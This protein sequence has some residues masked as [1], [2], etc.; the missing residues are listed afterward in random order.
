MS[1]F[2]NIFSFTALILFVAFFI[3]CKNNR[4][5]A[6]SSNDKPVLLED[7]RFQIDVYNIGEKERW[8]LINP[9]D[10]GW[11]KVKIPSA[12]NTY[13]ESLWGYEGV[14]WYASI[15]PYSNSLKSKILHL[16]FNRVNYD[17]QVWLNGKF[18]G[19]NRG[20]FLPFEFDISGLLNKKRDNWLV[21]RVDN[22]PR[23]NWLP[24]SKQ[25][26][27]VQY[28]GILQPVELIALDSVFIAD[29]HIQTKVLDKQA[30]ILFGLKI[31]NR[32]HKNR[33]IHIIV[34]IS[35]KST[36]VSQ[37]IGL[38]CQSNEITRKTIKM[39]VDN[40]RLWSPESPNLYDL[41]VVLK[42]GNK[43]CDVKKYRFGVRSIETEGRNIL[44]NGKPLKIK[45]FNRYDIFARMGHVNNREVIKKD[46]LKIKKS[47]ANVIRVHYPQ[48]PSTLD[49]LDEI[50]L[51]LIEELP[52]NWWGQNWWTDEK[53][54]Q[55]TTILPQARMM[56][57]KM[58]NRDKNHPSVFAWSLANECKT[59][60]KTGT[61]VVQELIKEAHSLDSSRL[62]TFSVN[63]D[64]NAHPAYAMADFV[65]CNVYFGNDEAYHEAMLDSLVRQPAEM[66]IKRQCSVYPHKPMIVSEFGAAGIYGLSGNVSFSED[67]QAEYIEKIWKAIVNVPQCSGGILWCWA[68]YYHRKY[69]TQSYSPFG[70]YGVLNV[71][72]KEKKSFKKIKQFF[73]TY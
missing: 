12:W 14:A 71:E 19:E 11:K 8:Y 42:N 72:R 34:T 66:F 68:D 37:I 9:Y 35:D 10:N 18:I 53:V 41:K 58:V 33:D 13:D 15:I 6:H 44:L 67:W 22:K 60:T 21:I 26:E 45:G 24:A 27:W 51:L 36:N 1:R 25:I 29:N 59:E 46:L 32:S 17:S 73:K 4:K 31:N 57:E 30:E 43:N 52:L 23:I 3:S 61:Y 2:R 28:G 69:F 39:T 38:Q 40:A 65:S 49:L 56:L 54:E 50:G 62:V 55:D 16:K 5:D 63:N 7:W 70:P 47:G 48:S 20:G 64:V